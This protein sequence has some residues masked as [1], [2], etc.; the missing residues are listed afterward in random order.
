MTTVH[1]TRPTGRDPLP[2]GANRRFSWRFAASFTVTI[3]TVLVLVADPAAANVYS[4]HMFGAL[5][6]PGEPALIAGHRGDRAEAPENTI[7]ALQAALDSRMEF[8]ET[9]IQLTADRVPVLLH[10][11]TVDRTTD[12]SG[13]IQDLTLEQVKALDAGSWYSSDYAG[14]TVP[15]LAEFFA[16]FG[17]SRKKAILELKGFWTVEDVHIVISQVY[18]SGVQD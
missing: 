9:D 3:A 17:Q 8:V 14:A 13:A 7:P 15:T 1:L 11:A 5:R 16:I 4:M 12:G 18:A 6:S 10:D 2:T